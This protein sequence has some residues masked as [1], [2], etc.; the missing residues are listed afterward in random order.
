MSVASAG[1][2]ESEAA[3]EAD[4]AYLFLAGSE[5]AEELHPRSG[6]R[7]SSEAV[8]AKA[9]HPRLDYYPSQLRQ[10]AGS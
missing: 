2:E 7:Y 3:A 1:V 6:Q 8:E 4:Y 9:R 10:L 5:A